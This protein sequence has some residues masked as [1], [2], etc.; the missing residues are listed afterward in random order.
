M[1]FALKLQALRTVS[2]EFP[3]KPSKASYVSRPCDNLVATGEAWV[4]LS[5]RYL[6]DVRGHCWWDAQAEVASGPIDLVPELGFIGR[7]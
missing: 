4:A 1:P 3:E 6:Q 5:M 7:R 2:D